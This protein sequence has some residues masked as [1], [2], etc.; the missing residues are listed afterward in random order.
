MNFQSIHIIQYHIYPKYS[1]IILSW[2]NTIDITIRMSSQQFTP[3]KFVKMRLSHQKL[4]ICIFHLEHSQLMKRGAGGL[5]NPSGCAV[6]EP[7]PPI[8][9]QSSLV[10]DEEVNLLCRHVTYATA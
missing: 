5:I 6:K 7:G 1:S 4:F 2:M 8:D 3:N 10:L 9:L